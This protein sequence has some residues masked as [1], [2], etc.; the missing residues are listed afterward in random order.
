MR[1][2]GGEAHRR[3]PKVA[4]LDVAVRTDE[5]VFRFEV[6]IKDRKRVKVLQAEHDLCGVEARHFFGKH[7]VAPQV[8]KEHPTRD[9]LHDE[10]ELGLRLEGTLKAEDEGV[11]LLSVRA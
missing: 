9:I 10:V 7:F 2:R 8:C 4:Q 1:C 11:A 3:E 6:T 5:D